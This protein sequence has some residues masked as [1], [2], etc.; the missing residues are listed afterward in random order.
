[1]K[2]PLCFT[3]TA[4]LLVFAL[5][6]AVQ[7]QSSLTNGLL[8]Y[9]PLDGDATDWSGN[10]FHG[11]PVGAMPATDR[12][13]RQNG[14]FAIP[15]GSAHILVPVDFANAQT[16]T[17]C[18]WVSFDTITHGRRAAIF[19]RDD[20]G[21]GIL[22]A[23]W[24]FEL[25]HYELRL[26]VGSAGWEG[27]A[28][29]TFAPETHHWYF[30]AGTYDRAVASLY[31]DGLLT[32]EA[33][34]T[35]GI[36]YAADGIN[37]LGNSALWGDQPLNGRIDEV[38]IYNRAL[39]ASEV[40]LLYHCEPP[41]GTDASPTAL[42]TPSSL[43]AAVGVAACIEVNALGATPLNYQWQFNGTDLQDG[44]RISGTRSDHLQISTVAPEDAGTYTV[45]VSNAYGS[46]TSNPATLTVLLRPPEIAAE[47]G[48]QTVVSGAPATFAVVATGSLPLTFQWRRNGVDLTDG[49]Q[50]SGTQTDSLSIAAA[51]IEDLGVYTVVIRNAYGS[52]TSAPA[53][54]TLTLQPP[55]VRSDPVDQSV[56]S[57]ADA[58]FGV[59]A[60]GSLPLTYQW[61]RNGVEITDGGRI[62]GAHTDTLTIKGAEAAD[63]G[64]Y[65]VEVR[66][67]YGWTVSFPAQLTVV[68]A[69]P[70]V[71][72]EPQ[73]QTV[74]LGSTISFWVQATGSLPLS[75][76]WQ[77]DGVNVV[78]GGRFAGA[79]TSTLTISDL[80][81]AELGN[82][83]VVVENALGRVQGKSALLKTS[84]AVLQVRQDGA[85]VVLSWNETGRRLTLQRST[86]LPPSE[87]ADILES[88]GRDTLRLPSRDARMFFRLRGEQ[89]SQ[90]SV[91]SGLFTWHEAKADAESRGGHLV[92]ITSEAEWAEITVQLGAAV[93]DGCDPWIGASDEAVEGDW[94][95]VTGEPWTFNHWCDGEP[96]DAGD[97]DYGR[98][99][100]GCG[101]GRWNDEGSEWRACYIL[102]LD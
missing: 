17:I 81:L 96:N 75:Y 87:W 61:Q 36:S 50:V 22:F 74:A 73:G 79:E 16:V 91:V 65:M 30:V 34:S 11:T 97:E 58:S 78:D 37:W 64:L 89:S 56:F 35:A 71:T 98:I 23:Q 60:V 1:M 102:E 4:L 86:G 46:V 94:A 57:G 93:L 76:Q 7:A 2:I 83:S 100:G 85:E 44:G 53:T 42:V 21:R 31:V 45:V 66:N 92:T 90:Y 69:P 18:A 13:G 77:R 24:Y 26:F 38:R 63:L 25:E 82:Y 10:G 49:G 8:A 20:W 54:L 5:A 15:G 67:A 6:G 47:P 88:Q 29:V 39:S 99:I 62:T 12:F 48:N 55:N 51:G 72:A 19:D 70:T 101:D 3:L 33:P 9:Y 28:W 27:Q 32:A 95:W 43:S 52:V 80:S 59:T 41:G 84:S 40:Q 14:A 68:L